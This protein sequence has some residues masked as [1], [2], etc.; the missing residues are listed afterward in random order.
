MHENS[1]KDYET[2]IILA[3]RRAEALRRELKAYEQAY[4]N[5]YEALCDGNYGTD[6]KRAVQRAVTDAY[7]TWEKESK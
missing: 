7:Q 3:D 4:A 1:I 2:E 5:V 6:L